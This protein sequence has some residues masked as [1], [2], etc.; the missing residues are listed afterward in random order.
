MLKF[1]F[2][3]K[4]GP[5]FFTKLVSCMLHFVALTTI[6][7]YMKFSSV[8]KMVSYILMSALAGHQNLHSSR[9]E[10][11]RYNHSICIV[12]TC[13]CGEIIIPVSSYISTGKHTL[14]GWRMHARN[15]SLNVRN[16]SLKPIQANQLVTG[17]FC[18]S[19]LSKSTIF[20]WSCYY[21]CSSYRG[22]CG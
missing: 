22:L 9:P 19:H 16:L 12:C 14:D 10:H 3:E 2:S 18:Y 11:P 6:V 15:L 4:C 13:T 7:W 20:I 21:G 8:V 17:Q 5:F 1:K